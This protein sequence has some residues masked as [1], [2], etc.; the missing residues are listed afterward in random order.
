LGLWDGFP[1]WKLEVPISFESRFF[2]TFNFFQSIDIESEIA[3][4]IWKCELGAMDKRKVGNR[5]L[6][7]EKHVSKDLQ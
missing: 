3:F 6:K 4:F 2:Y 5:P 7:P 1:F